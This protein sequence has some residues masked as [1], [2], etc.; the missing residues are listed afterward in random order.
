M[1]ER[2]PLSETLSA[3]AAGALP[4]GARLV[5]EVHLDG[6][7][8]CRTEVARFEALGGALL[9]EAEPSEL[10]PGGL[11]RALAALDR[12]TPEPPSEPPSRRLTLD[13][14]LARG[15][16]IPLGP[17]L[18]VKRLSRFADPGERLVLIRAAGGQALP[19][20]GHAGPE[21]LVVLKGAFEDQLGRYGPGDLSERGP[22]DRHQPV[23][24][25][26]ETCLCLSATDAPLRLS[27][28]ARWLQPVLGL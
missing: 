13:E 26:G 20:H 7:A 3:Y 12:P 15:F 23:A 6:C 10:A 2:H 28:I 27:G 1:S 24:V 5:L 19:E 8:H 25:P 21:R 14:V 9:C 17:S 18:A 4:A 22:D 11:E 16:W